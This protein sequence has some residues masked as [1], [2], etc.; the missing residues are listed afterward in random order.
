M[1]AGTPKSVL[2]KLLSDAGAAAGVLIP[3]RRSDD[4]RGAPV[5][6]GCSAKGGA[7]AAPG[8]ASSWD[9]TT[10]RA[11]P[12]SPAGSRRKPVPVND[13]SALRATLQL[14]VFVPVLR[15][16]ARTGGS[17]TAPTRAERGITCR[18]GGS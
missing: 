14:L 2:V 16:K 3:D 4:A 9:W 1:I 13:A 10:V 18:R 6:S 5:I 12:G 7:G 8:A 15:I 11:N 17:K